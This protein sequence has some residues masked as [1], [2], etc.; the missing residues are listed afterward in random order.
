MTDSMQVAIVTV[1]NSRRIDTTFIESFEHSQSHIGLK[2]LLKLGIEH[3]GLEAQAERHVE[4][5]H[6]RKAREEQLRA[7]ADI[8]RRERGPPRRAQ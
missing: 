1:K 3:I 7:N 8:G 6:P 4:R 2:V 5:R